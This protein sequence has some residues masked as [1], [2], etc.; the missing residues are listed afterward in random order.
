MKKV[1]QKPAP[2]GVKI[3]SIINWIVAFW[4]VIMGFILFVFGLFLPWLL[5]RVPFENLPDGTS[6][7]FLQWFFLI[8][9]GLSLILGIFIP[10]VARGLWKGKNWARTSEIYLLGLMILFIFWKIIIHN[11][12]YIV[13]SIISA[14]VLILII[15]LI[16]RY[17]I[18]DKKVKSFFKGV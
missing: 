4:I 11:S 8:T 18:Y 5:Q 7:L 10:F 14:L 3:I 12:S 6:L 9:G 17:L 2:M 1:Q 16:I 15:C 13:V